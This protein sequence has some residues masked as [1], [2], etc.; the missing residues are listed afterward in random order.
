MDDNDSKFLSL[1]QPGPARYAKVALMFFAFAILGLLLLF[2]RREQ[3][4]SLRAYAPPVTT[5]VASSKPK[6]R[7]TKVDGVDVDDSIG[8]VVKLLPLGNRAGPTPESR[9]VLLF[10]N[11]GKTW[12]GENFDPPQVS[13]KVIDVDDG[14]VL[15]THAPACLFGAEHRLRTSMRNRNGYIVVHEIGAGSSNLLHTAKI[16]DAAESRHVA[17]A[18]FPRAICLLSTEHFAVSL[19]GNIDRV[20]DFDPEVNTLTKLS[21]LSSVPEA[22]GGTLRDATIARGTLLKPHLDVKAWFNVNLKH[23]GIAMMVPL[24]VPSYARNPKVTDLIGTTLT[25]AQRDRPESFRPTWRTALKDI[26]RCHAYTFNQV[27]EFRMFAFG[28]GPSLI[29]CLMTFDASTGKLM[30]ETAFAPLKLGRAGRV[31]DMDLLEEI[32]DRHVYLQREGIIE[33]VDQA[34]SKVTRAFGLAEP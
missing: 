11:G 13:I 32:D 10:T 7:M 21:D 27:S 6:P 20:F 26:S 31:S 15:W 24:D 19:E 28:Y 17:L 8:T 16:N 33:V 22:C 5:G 1:G 4:A 25:E 2:F 29:P 34:T 3:Q 12:K 18:E 23:Q 9:S 14:K 30:N